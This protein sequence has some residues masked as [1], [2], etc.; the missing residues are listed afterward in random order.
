MQTNHFTRAKSSDIMVTNKEILYITMVVLK[1]S[2]KCRN[3]SY[4]REEKKFRIFR[5][6][7]RLLPVRLGTLKPYQNT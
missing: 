2:E 1:E 3:S 4:F 6:K 5:L 7:V